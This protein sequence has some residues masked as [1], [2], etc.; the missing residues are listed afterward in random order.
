MKIID[1]LSIKKIK[2]ARETLAEF[3]TRLLEAERRLDDL[4]RCAEIC[5][6]TNQFH[7]LG[8]FVDEA[9]RF[10]EDRL[11]LI[12]FSERTETFKPENIQIVETNLSSQST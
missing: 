11:D 1:P 10:L 7:L 8:S 5:M 3:Q 6:V 2:E 12:E 9:N 4:A